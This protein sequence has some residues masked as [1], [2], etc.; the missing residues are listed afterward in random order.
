MSI[1]KSLFFLKS[2]QIG[3]LELKS[4]KTEENSLEELNNRFEEK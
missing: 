3:I 2:N 4:R 1:K